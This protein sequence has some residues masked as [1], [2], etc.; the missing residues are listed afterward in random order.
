MY[1]YS[2]KGKILLLPHNQD[3]SETCKVAAA[4]TKL[5]GCSGLSGLQYSLCKVDAYNRS[6]LRILWISYHLC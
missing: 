1:Y 2:Q 6:S 4:N 3:S 5:A